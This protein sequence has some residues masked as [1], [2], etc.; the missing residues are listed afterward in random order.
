MFNSRVFWML[1]ATV[2][3]YLLHALFPLFPLDVTGI[4][5][6]LVFI[7]SLFGVVVAFRALARRTIS[8]HDVWTSLPF[9]TALVAL[10]V[11]VLHYQFPTFPFGQAELM[12]F[13][14]WL[15][16]QFGIVPTFRLVANAENA[17]KIK[18]AKALKK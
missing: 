10:A 6:W 13:V 12:V 11:F 7:L 14:L 2:A 9:W 15:L 17:A 4:F 18:L 16:D 1:V 8:W 3:Y 5:N